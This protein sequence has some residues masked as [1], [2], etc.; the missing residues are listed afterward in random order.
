MDLGPNNQLQRTDT[1]ETYRLGRDWQPLAFSN[2]GRVAPA[3][4]VFAGYGIVAPKSDD[5]DEYD[6]YVHLDVTDKWVCV[7]RFMPEDISAEQRQHLSGHSSLRYKAMVARDRGAH[8][9][10][11]V[12]GPRSN[13]KNQ[14]VKL[15]FD[16]SL[17]GSS[18][19]V[20]SVHDDVVQS[21][22]SQSGKQLADL[23]ASLDGGKL[24]MGFTLE[25]VQLAADIRIEKVK[26]QGR[27]V[28]GRLRAKQ[29]PKQE[30]IIIGAHIDHL[31]TGTSSSSLAREDEVGGIHFGADDNASGIAAML[32][33]AEYLTHEQRNGRM[34]LKRDVIFAGWSGEELGLIG[35]SKFASEVASNFASEVGSR[36]ASHHAGG[37]VVAHPAASAEH[38]A[39]SAHAPAGQPGGEQHELRPQESHPSAAQWLLRTAA[40]IP[41]VTRCRSTPLSRHV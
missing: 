26:R 32:E 29:N 3:E 19:P 8:G 31:G 4:V 38:A 6:S 10:I 14:L 1:K 12:S 15:Q 5:F 36:L 11:V 24:A 18:L 22:L 33:I 35:S 13:V 39:G 16:G 30:S 41:T 9:L 28:L 23:Q 7:F 21:W 34:E 40:A 20:V 17:A 37:D 25:G 2:T 27:N